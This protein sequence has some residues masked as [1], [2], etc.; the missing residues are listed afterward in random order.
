[1]A[2]TTSVGAGVAVPLGHQEA[3]ILAATEF[4][5]MAAQLR[6]LTPRDWAQ[7]TVCELWDVRAMAAHVLGMAEAQ[8]SF[9]QF[10]H[11]GHEGPVLIFH[12]RVRRSQVPRS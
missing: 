4:D 9:R 11:D 8:A 10:A 7:P 3:M 5:R 2:G 6:A 12:H 1:M